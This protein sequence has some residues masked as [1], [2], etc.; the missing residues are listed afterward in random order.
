MTCVR[1]QG[2]ADES[3]SERCSGSA[4]LTVLIVTLLA[5]YLAWSYCSRMVDG[6]RLAAS[7][8]ERVRSR[9]LVDSGKIWLQARLRSRASQAVLVDDPQHE[10][11]GRINLVDEAG[12]AVFQPAAGV[13]GDSLG[14]ENE[15]GRLNVNALVA[16]DAEFPGTG[17]RMLMALP[18]MTRTTADSILDWLDADSKPRSI[19]TERLQSGPGRSKPTAGN[20]SLRTLDELLLVRG[21]RREMLEG[22]GTHPGWRSWLSVHS[23]ESNRRSDGSLR[24]N[25]NQKSLAKL[26]DQIAFALGSRAARYIVAWRM[27][28]P[29]E[30]VEFDFGSTDSA[31]SADRTSDA[32]LGRALAQHGEF[33]AKPPAEIPE[34]DR[35]RNGMDL[36]AGGPFKVRSLVDLF[37]RPVSVLIDGRDTL[38]DS[39]WSGDPATVFY[40]LPKLEEA[41][42]ISDKS[43]LIGRIN[44]H[45]ARPEVLQG[46]PGMD[47][48]LLAA[49][50]RQ[51][52][53]SHGMRRWLPREQASI[54]WLYHSGMVDLPRLRE[55]A[56]HITVGGDVFRTRVI[57]VSPANGPELGCEII[58]DAASRPPR[59]VAHCEL[60]EVLAR[61]LASIARRQTTSSLR[62]ETF[63]GSRRLRERKPNQTHLAAVNLWRFP[64]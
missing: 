21:V 60:S 9:S 56:P 46:I 55:L 26:Y 16:I 53:D 51:R 54:G 50:L 6:A 23:S 15:S 5:A 24:I 31:A 38:I 11:P 35:F 37:G 47:N 43:R 27:N 14:V 64:Q 7:Q 33:D 2:V 39:P 20:R 1:R 62:S 18:M 13:S 61:Q 8:L 29:F 59:I 63:A 49:I 42:T 28:G 32:A 17:R 44:L 3:S 4:L 22:H 36:S 12:F 34:A 25:I 41:L 40:M 45:A 58:V 30:D 19:G 52:F 57:S 48:A 10:F